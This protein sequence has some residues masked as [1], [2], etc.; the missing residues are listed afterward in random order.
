M[1]FL[2]EA[3]QEAVYEVVKHA[4]KVSH[5]AVQTLIYRSIQPSVYTGS[6]FCDECLSTANECLEEH[7]KCLSLLRHVS[8]S[9]ME[10][11]IHWYVSR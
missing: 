8:A 9:T 7:K 2:R 5:L 4:E 3:G 10:L 11:Y 1:T 6:A